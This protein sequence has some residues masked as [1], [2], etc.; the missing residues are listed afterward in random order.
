VHGG[1]GDTE[2]CGG[3][4]DRDHFAIVAGGPDGSG[5]D[6]VVGAQSGDAVGGERVAGTGQPSLAGEDRGD[7]PVGVTLGELAHERDRVLVGA[8]GVAA[9]A[10]QAHGVLGDRAALPYDP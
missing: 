2:L 6:L 1:G 9:G 5:G 7:L 3:V 8:A 4:R 10:R